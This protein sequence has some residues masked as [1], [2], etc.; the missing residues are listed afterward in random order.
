MTCSKGN[1][2]LI[3]FNEINKSVI[4]RQFAESLKIT[5]P[6]LIIVVYFV[7]YIFNLICIVHV[8]ISHACNPGY[9]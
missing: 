3:K 2:G 8:Y 9:E 1:S 5:V 4:A 6:N 7:L